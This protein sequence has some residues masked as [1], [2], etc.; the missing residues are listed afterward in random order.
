[1]GSLEYVDFG[2]DA[3]NGT[4]NLRSKC[5]RIEFLLVAIALKHSYTFEF[6]D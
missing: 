6:G 2:L 1:M 5:M 3:K 4:K